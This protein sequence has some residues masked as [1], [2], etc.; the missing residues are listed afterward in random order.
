M[1]RRA[2]ELPFGLG[3]NRLPGRW[4]IAINARGWELGSVNGR[5]LDAP[6]WAGPLGGLEA[7]GASS[8][9]A[10]GK[11]SHRAVKHG[12]VGRQHPRMLRIGGLEGESTLTPSDAQANR[13]TRVTG[14]ILLRLMGRGSCEQRFCAHHVDPHHRG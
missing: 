3:G 2:L 6:R 13:V 5:S 9:R 8:R 4:R 1:F 7:L 10:F 12:G 14:H 11:G